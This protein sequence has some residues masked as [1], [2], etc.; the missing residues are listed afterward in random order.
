MYVQIISLMCLP[1]FTLV[2]TIVVHIELWQSEAGAE[3]QQVLCGEL[4]CGE[5]SISVKSVTH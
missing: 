3:T 5:L 4:L 2:N 1:L